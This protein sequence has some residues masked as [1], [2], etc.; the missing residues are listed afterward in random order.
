MTKQNIEIIGTGIIDHR[1]S[2][3]PQVVQ[4]PDGELLCSYSVGEGPESRGCSDISR[5]TDNG[6]SWNHVGTILE[7]GKVP[8]STN[9]IRISLASDNET[10]L[11]YGCRS[12]RTREQK[13]GE[14]KNEP[15]FMTSDDRGKS[16][17]DP[18]I[19]DNPY[20]C[21]LEYSYNA[22][23]TSSGKL[24]APAAILPAKDKLGEKVIVFV[25]E[26]GGK[27]WPRHTVVFSDPEGKHGYFEHKFYE[28]SPGK[29]LSICWTISMDTVEDRENH[30]VWSYDDG[31]TWT[32]PMPTGI[33]GQT[34]SPIHIED[35]K[36]L[37]LYNRRYGEQG[38]VMKLVTITEN[39]LTEH[40]EAMMYDAK[41]KRSRPEGIEYGVNEFDDFAFGF[42]T[43]IRL[44]DGSYF[45]TH[46]CKEGGLHAIR[47]TR[48]KVNW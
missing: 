16:W 17:S 30:F 3:F 25:S 2:A 14:G 28:V 10:L 15:V 45:A 33:M 9:L 4:M 24:L 19:I 1:D 26:D 43:A 38:V 41:S 5:S 47:W 12:Y 36:F 32:T 23:V 46:W 39:K 20:N 34:M 22:I 44:Q 40:F 48:L 35:D 13:F 42:P 8:Y 6:N 18:I 27:T 21:P 31:E 11:A 29:I 7:E 37:L